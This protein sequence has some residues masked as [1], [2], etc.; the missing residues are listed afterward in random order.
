MDWITL[1]FWTSDM[2]QGFF[3]AYFSKGE[4]VTDN[5]RIVVNYM[6]TWFIVDAFI[7][8]PGWTMKLLPASIAGDNSGVGDLGKIAK[9]AR[10]GRILRLIRLLKMKKL[11]EALVDQIES[12]Y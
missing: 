7:V 6:K 4:V 3:L 2:I 11:L 5:G 8:V 10:L 1:I 12:E 9:F